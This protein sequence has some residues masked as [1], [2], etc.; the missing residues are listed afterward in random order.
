MEAQAIPA[1]TRGPTLPGTVA[2]NLSAAMSLSGVVTIFGTT[3][4][5]RAHMC[6]E[7]GRRRAG[8]A[9]NSLGAPEPGTR[10]VTAMEGK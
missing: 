9:G 7:A 6:I 8:Q 4:A 2:G 3:L 1:P 5:S 10:I